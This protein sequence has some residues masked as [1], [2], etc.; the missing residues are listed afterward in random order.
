VDAVLRTRR[1]G[2]QKEQRKGPTT[3][4]KKKGADQPQKEE[5][6]E[7]LVSIQIWISRLDQKTS[8]RQACGNS[9]ENCKWRAC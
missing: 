6:D 4:R 9:V 2:S 3:E 5:S 1:V 7:P 8:Q